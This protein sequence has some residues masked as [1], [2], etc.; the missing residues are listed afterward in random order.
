M[1]W[2]L[3]WTG[4]ADALT[5]MAVDLALLDGCAAGTS[6][7]TLR[8]Y[9][10]DPPA[11][12]LGYA[13]DPAAILDLDACR[14]LGV[15]WVRRP[16]GGR[17][18]LHGW[19][20]TYSVAAPAAMLPGGVLA[21]YRRLA[22]GLVVGLRRLG[23][24][25]ELVARPRPARGRDA[26]CFLAASWW[27]VGVGGRKLIG[28]AQARR[29]GAVLQH[30]SLPLAP[31]V[32]AFCAVVRAE[33][34]AGRARVREALERSSTHLG[35]VLAQAPAPREVADALAAG[36]AEVLGADLVASGLTAAEA[37]AVRRLVAEGR[38]AVPRGC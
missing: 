20:L 17:A 12:S 37:A 24:E 2:R 27:E 25:A 14:R 29:R 6:P 22:R 5:N 3:L 13:Q 7:P 36:L 18:V 23:V 38:A 10:W 15:G 30:G 35:A 31:W 19:D 4:A 9:T 16:S 8:F 11:V 1:R 26:A 32:E 33:G 28:S 34:E 21:V